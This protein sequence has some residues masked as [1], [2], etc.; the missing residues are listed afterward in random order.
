MVDQFSDHQHTHT[1]SDRSDYFTATTIQTVGI[2]ELTYMNSEGLSDLRLA[3]LISWHFWR[4]E[5]TLM[6]PRE[7]TEAVEAEEKR[8]IESFRTELQRVLGEKLEIKIRI[9]GGCVEAEVEDLRFV[10]LE[11]SSSGKQES[12]TVVTLLG[13]CPSCGVE[14]MSEPIYSFWGLGQRLERF[15]PILDHYC[16]ARFK[17]HN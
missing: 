7:A 16:H 12:T 6:K 15:E 5:G 14:T 10:A 8:R 4:T 3:A 9:N 1:R 17:Q 11:L 13:R 2:N